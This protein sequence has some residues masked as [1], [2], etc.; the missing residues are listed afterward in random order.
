MNEP[1]NEWA[2]K[3]TTTDTIAII[4]VVY[5]VA[6]L[7]IGSSVFATTLGLAWHSAGLATVE[8]Q[9]L[10]NSLPVFDEDPASHATSRPME[11]ASDAQPGRQNQTG[12]ANAKPNRTYSQLILKIK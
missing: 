2:S 7:A 4:T 3:A 10:R 1:T 9:Q 5:G 11:M 6:L 8:Q 12:P